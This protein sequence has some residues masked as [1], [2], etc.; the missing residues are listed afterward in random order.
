MRPIRIVHFA[1]F[2]LGVDTHG[3]TDPELR[4]NGRVLDFLDSLDSLV[5]YAEDNDA[6]L[7]IFAGD[8][9]HVHRPD[10]TYQREFGE[11]IIRLSE[12]CPVVMIPGN[13]DLPGSLEKASTLDLFYT[14]KVQNVILG[15]DYEIHKVQTK[16]GTVQVCTFPWP[17]SA[18]FVT[19]QETKKL[20]RADLGTLFHSRVSKELNRLTEE[21]DPEFPAVLVGHFSVSNAVYGSERGMA[22][23]A[24]AEVSIQDLANP[25]WDYVALG[26]IHYRQCLHEEPPVVYAGSLDRVDFGE[27]HDDKGFV[28]IEIAEKTTWEFVDIDARPFI[29]IRADLTN[30]KRPTDKL[31][32][33]IEKRDLNRAVVRVKVTIEANREARLR[34][35]DIYEA[36]QAK[37][38]YHVHGIAIDRVTDSRPTRLDTERPIASLAHSELLD[39]YFTSLG[40]NGKEKRILLDLA[41]DIMEEV[42]REQQNV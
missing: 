10:P 41:A 20:S 4:M 28:W 9:F 14:L 37:G 16:R 30:T 18:Q 19:A 34:V 8:A 33:K 22:I 31:L 24:D 7:A 5:D 2:H 36:I 17:L 29:T 25:A 39:Y 32:A 27:E 13:H 21:L 40:V 35:K 3:P 12:Q 15:W 38:A 11:R 26:H 23:G 1:D 42:N 6:D